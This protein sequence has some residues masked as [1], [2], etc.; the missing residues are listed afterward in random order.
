MAIK[1]KKVAPKKVT[2]KKTKVSSSIFNDGA[3]FHPK[4]FE[5]AESPRPFMTFRI[6]RQTVYWII[7]LAFISALTLWILKLQLDVLSILN[8]LNQN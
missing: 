6:T 3:R 8:S 7:L 1:K 4:S 5:I 2:A